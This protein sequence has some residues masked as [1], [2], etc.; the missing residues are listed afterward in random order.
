MSETEVASARVLGGAGALTKE[1]I[2]RAARR[3]FAD[4]G[5]GATSVRAIAAEAGADPALVI[6]HF[7]SKEQLFLETVAIEGRFDHVTHGP[8]ESMGARLVESLLTESPQLTFSIW[9]AMLRASD[10]EQVRSRLI[11]AMEEMFIEP[12]APRLVGPLPLLRAR[13][14]AASIS[15][16]L[17]AVAILGDPLIVEAATEDLVQLY[18]ASIQTIVDG[19]GKSA[20]E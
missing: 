19:P 6:R 13:L 4:Q 14:V 8:L 3:L 17:D 11:A 5:Y 9:R 2:A 10:S 20:P 15:G 1:S 16:L 18:G 12:L 7:G